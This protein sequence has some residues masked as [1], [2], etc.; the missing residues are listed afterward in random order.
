MSKTDRAHS[1]DWLPT[2]LPAKV[3]LSAVE[4]PIVEVLRA[5]KIHEIV[6]GQLSVK[7]RKDIVRAT[8]LEFNKKLDE[9]PM[10]DQVPTYVTFR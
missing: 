5:R 1:F 4:G 7:E 6:V 9:R 10:N 2:T 8:L 3:I